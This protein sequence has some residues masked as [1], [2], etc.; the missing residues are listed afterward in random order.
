MLELENTMGPF[1]FR[2]N[3]RNGLFGVS[4]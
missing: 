1:R 2:I 4:C 3:S